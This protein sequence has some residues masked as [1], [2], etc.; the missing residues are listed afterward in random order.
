[1][2]HD[3]R[4]CAVC[5]CGT[6]AHKGKARRAAQQKRDKENAVGAAGARDA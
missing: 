5:L 1:M 4:C 6:C 2:K 3:A